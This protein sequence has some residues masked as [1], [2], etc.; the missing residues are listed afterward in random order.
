M[1]VCPWEPINGF[2][3]NSEFERFCAWI[4]G[5]VISKGARK[6]PVLKRYLGIESF[7]EEW[8]QHT[9]SQTTWRLVH[10]DGPFRGFFEQC[11]D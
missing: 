6:V 2:S 9:E 10:P 11:I 8:Y 7:L 5:L 4:N 3:T 1:T